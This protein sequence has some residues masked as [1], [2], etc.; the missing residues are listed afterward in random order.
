MTT[1]ATS[2]SAIEGADLA[3][4]LRERKK[5][6]TRESLEAAALDLFA[7][8]GFDATTIEEIADACEV[9]PRT[10]FRYFPTK[11]AV[12]FGDGETR[13]DALVAALAAQPT[14]AAP[15]DALHAAMLELARSYRDDR[16]VLVLRKKVLQESVQLRAYKAEHQRGWEEA[17]TEELARR[18]RAAKH[19]L[20]RFELRLLSGVAVAAL[21][22]AL[23]TWIDDKRA[24]MPDLLVDRAF[25]ELGDG[26][27]GIGS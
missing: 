15:L 2:S 1:V 7:R 3:V 17:L 24:P 13:C 8:Q 23:D 10:F 19:P 11:E 27:G 18:A 20:S 16:D 9:S 25:T 4:G 6:R 14:T 5:A 12:L 22:A 21:R 26:L